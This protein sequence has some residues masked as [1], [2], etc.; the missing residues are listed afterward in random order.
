MRKYVITYRLFIPYHPQTSEPVEVSNR[1]IKLIF[2]EDCKSKR[3]KLVHKTSRCLMG[4]QGHFQNEFR[5]V[6]Y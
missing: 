4:L 1:Q 3:E 5:D 6:S 2:G